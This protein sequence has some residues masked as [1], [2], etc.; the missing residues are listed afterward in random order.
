MKRKDLMVIVEIGEGD[1]ASITIS[2]C[3][4]SNMLNSSVAW[5]KGAGRLFTRSKLLK[6]FIFSGGCYQYLLCCEL[7]FLI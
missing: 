6:E 4:C 2:K 7:V 5:S 3:L 1:A